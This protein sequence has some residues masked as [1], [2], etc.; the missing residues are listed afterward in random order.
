MWV[1]FCIGDFFILASVRLKFL[2]HVPYYI[3]Y[4][5]FKGKFFLV[6]YIKVPKFDIMNTCKISG[7]NLLKQK[8]FVKGDCCKMDPKIPK[9]RFSRQTWFLGHI[10]PQSAGLTL[11]RVKNSWWWVMD[12]NE[13]NSEKLQHKQRIFSCYW[14]STLAA[15][16]SSV[17]RW[18]VWLSTERAGRQ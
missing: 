3:K 2:P 9:I 6:L 12:K 1:W 14:L 8:S 7:P 18:A 17:G 11:L 10:G 16:R 4:H 13:S 5:F 15:G